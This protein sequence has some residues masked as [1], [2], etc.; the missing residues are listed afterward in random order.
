MSSYSTQFTDVSSV[1][2]FTGETVNDESDPTA[3]QVLEWI[4]QVEMEM[5]AKGYFTESLTGIIMDVPEGK[6]GSDHPLAWIFDDPIFSTSGFVV[7]LPHSPFISVSNVQRNIQGYQQTPDW[8]DLVEGPEDNSHF[9]I[10]KDKFK[11][12]LRGVAL[13][14]Y[15]NAP[16]PGYQRLKLDYVWGYN[17]PATVLS[18]YAALK[19]SIMLLYAKYMRKEPVFD[20][21]IAGMRTALNK[22]TDVHQ[23]ILDRIELIELDW[24]PSK[25]T[26]V[27]LLP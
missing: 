3:E 7:S 12:G 15:S 24:I 9:L 27:A 6:I 22:F 21:N 11:A 23:H 5:V 20:I 8:E 10:V 4:E 19:V 25:F 18:E 16:Q 14:F 13:Y 17:L 2:A 26:G 1:E